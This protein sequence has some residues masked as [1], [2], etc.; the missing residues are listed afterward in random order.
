MTAPLPHCVVSH[1]HVGSTTY[2][3]IGGVAEYYS[4]PRSVAELQHAIRWAKAQ[5]AGGFADWLVLDTS[6]VRG[7]AYYTGTVFEGFDREGRLRAICGG[8]RD[9]SC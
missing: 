6:V 7:L 3:G 9:D 8:G 2:Y 5:E 1:Q 4:Q